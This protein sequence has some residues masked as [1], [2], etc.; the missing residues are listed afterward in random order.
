MIG[1]EALMGITINIGGWGLFALFLD[2]LQV[3]AASPFVALFPLAAV[4]LILFCLFHQE[5][6][7]A[8]STSVFICAV[9]GLFFWQYGIPSDLVVDE[10]R[11]AAFI[12]CTICAA[13]GITMLFVHHRRELISKSRNVSR[14][15]QGEEL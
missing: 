3:F 13:I 5:Y 1:K 11:I 9:L 14:V 4:F 2:Q 8:I 7:R 6:G 15:G 12:A 10:R